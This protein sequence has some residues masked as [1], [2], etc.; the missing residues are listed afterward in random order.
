MRLK[1]LCRIEHETAPGLVP[2]LPAFVA[3]MPRECELG[4]N[5]ESRTVG[6][7]SELDVVIDHADDVPGTG[8]LHSVTGVDAAWA[9]LDTQLR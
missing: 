8:S 5:L 7:M 4:A 6:H 2:V 9:H 3:T 1:R